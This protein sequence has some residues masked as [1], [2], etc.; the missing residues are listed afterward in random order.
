[1]LQKGG[2][3]KRGTTGVFEPMKPT[4]KAYGRMDSMIFLDFIGRR[5][6]S[7]TKLYR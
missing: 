2:V 3:A 4:E 1:M 7:E 6:R 5:S